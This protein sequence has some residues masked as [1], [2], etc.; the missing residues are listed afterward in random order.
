MFET[1][2]IAV[3]LIDDLRVHDSG[4]YERDGHVWLPMGQGFRHT[5]LEWL[6][7]VT[8][9]A[10]AILADKRNDLNE[11][12]AAPARSMLIKASASSQTI[13]ERIPSLLV[14][15]EKKPQ[16]VE[17]GWATTVLGR[18]QALLPTWSRSEKEEYSHNCQWAFTAR[19][20]MNGIIGFAG[21]LMKLSNMKVEQLLQESGQ[22]VYTSI[23]EQL[24]YKSADALW[25]GLKERLLP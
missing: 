3:L 6:D 22:D 7:K 10:M 9:V 14:Q 23:P 15:A 4:G 1:K 2:L 12:D 24:A 13:R 18:L 5:Q 19:P 17:H 21:C 11:C 16:D 20:E 8:K 25:P